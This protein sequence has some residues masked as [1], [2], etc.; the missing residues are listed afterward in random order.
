MFNH[1]LKTHRKLGLFIGFMSLCFT[2]LNCKNEKIIKLKVLQFNIWQ[3]G[4]VVK[5]GF[6]AVVDEIIRTDADLIAFSEVRNYNGVDFSNHI[7][8]ALKAKGHTYY[9]QPSQDTGL[10]SKYPIIEQT[11]LYPVKNDHGSI[12]K[13]IINILGVEVAFYSGHLDYLNC[14]LYLPRGY[15]GSTW[16]KLDSIVTDVEQI[17]KNNLE[18][19]RDEAIDTFIADAEK[20]IER[21]RLIVYGGDNNEPSHLDWI[22]ANKNLHDHNGVVINWRN[23]A[24]VEKHGFKDAYRE[25]YPNPVTHPG[26]TYPADNP[27]VPINKL[28]WSPEANDRDRIDFI[29][30]YPDERLQLIDAKI[31]G[32][33]GDVSKNK[34]V[35]ESTDDVFIEPLNIWPTDH[36]AV[37]ASFALKF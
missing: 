31:L 18:S 6:D 34:R 4:T 25:V 2:F 21:G 13:A 29:F 37:L 33:K 28:A 36:K 8:E 22:E 3:E 32:P 12:T 11:A 5:N 10:L 26:F 1:K 14:A 35:L 27:L 20:E 16:K 24:E 19:M 30:Y 9:A 15:D 7:V 17:Q 23:T